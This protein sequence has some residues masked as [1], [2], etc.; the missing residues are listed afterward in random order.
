MYGLLVRR[1]IRGR[2][3]TTWS[4][5]VSAV[6][7]NAGPGVRDIRPVIESITNLPV[8]FLPSHFH[9]DHVGNGIEFDER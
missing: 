2:I 7:F 1:G 3:S 8:I 5:V 6:L 4:L 9:Y